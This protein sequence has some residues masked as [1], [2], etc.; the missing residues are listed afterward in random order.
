VKQ[1]IIDYDSVDL[2][3]RHFSAAEIDCHIR[4]SQ[5]ML[6]ELPNADKLKSWWQRRI[7]DLI[8]AQEIG[9]WCAWQGIPTLDAKPENRDRERGLYALDIC[10]K[11]E[12]RFHEIKSDIESLRKHYT[13]ETLPTLKE[14]KNF[15]GQRV[16][17][18]DYL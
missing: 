7:S 11:L 8:L 16:D 2:I 6:G 9:D 13:S 5:E 18:A 17:N 1:T 15:I 4:A 10:R 14:I 12:S 3:L